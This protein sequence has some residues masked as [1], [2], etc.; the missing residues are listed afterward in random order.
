MIDEKAL[1]AA[2]LAFFST[3]KSK[4][5]SKAIRNAIEAYEAAKVLGL[6]HKK[7]VS[8]E[9][10]CLLAFNEC[11]SPQVCKRLGHCVQKDLSTG[12]KDAQP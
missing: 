10:D 6:I 2:S 9:M 7:A 12:K 8:P 11:S 1:E 4:P 5:L 3:P